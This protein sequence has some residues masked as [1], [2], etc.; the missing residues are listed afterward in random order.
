MNKKIHLQ[1]IAVSNET[2]STPYEN[3]LNN[4]L[5]SSKQTLY[6]NKYRFLG[7]VEKSQDDNNSN[8]ELSKKYIMVYIPLIYHTNIDVKNKIVEVSEELTFHIPTEVNPKLALCM[9]LASFRIYSALFLKGKCVEKEKVLILNSGTC[10]GYLACQLA[11]YLNCQIIAET[12]SAEHF[13]FL[14]KIKTTFKGEKI[15]QSNLENISEVVLEETLGHGVDCVIDFYPSHSVD[16]RRRIIES[17]SI[18]GRWVTIDPQ[19]QLDLPES[20]CM[21]LKNA[22]LNFLFDEAYGIYGMEL[23]KIKHIV[24]ESLLMLKEGKLTVFLENEYTSVEKFEET[25]LDE[26]KFG[27]AIINLEKEK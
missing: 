22:S 6:L 4:Q 18:G 2:Y 20:N 3:L 13:K 15:V 25:T 16:L 26:N 17:V 11:S 27:S 19:M 14:T 8:D 12:D 7:G 9:L 10:W 5:Q 21:F 24:E 23:G 1:H